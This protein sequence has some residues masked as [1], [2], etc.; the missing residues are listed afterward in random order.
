MEVDMHPVLVKCV[1]D[2]PPPSLSWTCG[3]DTVMT[4]A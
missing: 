2:F 4:H 3:V 1:F